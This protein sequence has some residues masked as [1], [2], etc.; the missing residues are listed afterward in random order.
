MFCFSDTSLFPSSSPLLPS[1]TEGYCFL[2]IFLYNA[3]FPLQRITEENINA[4][5]SIAANV[6]MF[7]ILALHLLMFPLNSFVFFLPH[8]L[9]IR[10]IFSI[11]RYLLI[12]DTETHVS[13]M[14][15]DIVMTKLNTLI[16]T[17]NTY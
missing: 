9:L 17:T 16:S 10:Y 7:I 15:S 5:F 14:T 12:Q 2:A 3:L 11:Y 4:S 1:P 8:F 6:N 13:N